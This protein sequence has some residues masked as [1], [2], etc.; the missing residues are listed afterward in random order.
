[1]LLVLGAAVAPIGAQSAR[2]D[3]LLA[4]S[5]W[6]EAVVQLDV[7]IAEGPTAADLSK[8]GR[9]HRELNDLA[10]SRSDYDAAIRADARFGPAYAGRAATRIRMSDGEGALSDLGQARQLGVDAPSLLLMEGLANGTLRRDGPAMAAFTRYI[11]AE[12]ADPVGWYYRGFTHGLAG[13]HAPAI[14]DLTQAIARGY[15]GPEAH[16]FRGLSHAALGNAAAACAD[17]REA[18]ARGDADAAARV[19][20][21]CS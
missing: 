15:A 9:A 6:R 17:G 11:E 13:R 4:A 16:R 5:A 21:Q 14:E 3:S 7:V 19:A 10:R 8:R 20:Q 1:M 2:I 12:P 18:A